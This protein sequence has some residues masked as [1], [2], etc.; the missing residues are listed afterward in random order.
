MDWKEFT[1]FAY[2]ALL[3]AILDYEKLRIHHA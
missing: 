2:I 1:G 3:K